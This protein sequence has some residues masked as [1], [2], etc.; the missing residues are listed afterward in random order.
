MSNFAFD[1]Q[2]LCQNARKACTTSQ[3]VLPLPKPGPILLGS[4]RVR[5]IS[6]TPCLLGVGGES[7]ASDE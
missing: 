3:G 2:I 7:R 4:S 5:M 1:V 6:A